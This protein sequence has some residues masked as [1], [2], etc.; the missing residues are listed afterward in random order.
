MLSSRLKYSPAP[1]CSKRHAM[2]VDDRASNYSQPPI[3]AGLAALSARSRSDS[4]HER[5]SRP[6]TA[7]LE[8]PL[9]ARAPGPARGR[10]TALRPFRS[11]SRRAKYLQSGHGETREY[12][13][14]TVTIVAAGKCG[15][16]AL[17]CWGTPYP[18]FALGMRG[19]QR[20]TNKS[21]F[22]FPRV[23]VTVAASLIEC[24]GGLC[25]VR[26]V[27]LSACLH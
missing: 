26:H 3:P 8:C 23:R 10:V 9:W 7:I 19:I 18:C 21:S 27:W 16:L 1:A 5:P 22:L 20:R 6:I 25:S 17:A 11:F 12:P 2:P 15:L 13:V 4:F 24:L 14:A